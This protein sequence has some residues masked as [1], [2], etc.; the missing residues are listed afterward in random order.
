MCGIIGAVGSLP[1]EGTFIA[2]RETLAHRGP[3]D[4]GSYYD[5]EASVAL[6]HRRLSIIDLSPAGRQPFWS[7]DRRFAIVFNGELYNYR[8]LKEEIGSRYPFSTKTDTEAL[9]ASFVVWGEACL[10]KLNG[11]FAFA[12]WDRRNK[13]LFCARDRI[14]VKPFFYCADGRG[15]R[16]A[17]EIKGLLALGVRPKPNDSIIY[18]YLAY[19]YYDHRPETFFDGIFRLPAGHSLTLRGGALTIKKYWDLADIAREPAPLALPAAKER[20]LALFSDSIRLRLRSDVPV[21]VNLSSGLDSNAILFFAEKI[22][23]APLHTFTTRVADPAYDEGELVEAALTAQQRA[24]WHPQVFDPTELQHLLGASLRVHDQ[25][26]GG[27]ATIARQELAAL[28]REVGVT[29]ILEGQGGDEILAGYRYYRPEFLARAPEHRGLSQ[30]ATAATR[31]EVLRED[32][33]S[34]HRFTP[35]PTPFFSPLLNAQYADLA[36]AKLPR[37]LRFGDHFSMHSGREYRQPLLDYRLVE[38]CFFLPD[39][40]KIIGGAQKVLIRE[41]MRDSVPPHT[42]AR[43]KKAFTAQQVPWLRTYAKDYC[44]GLLSSASFEARPYWD[45]RKAREL[46]ERFFA[47]EGDNSFFLWQ[48]VSLEQWL[49]DYTD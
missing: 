27:I 42:L 4:A 39:E 3:D 6:G 9:L 48:W 45:A 44:M 8:E 36:Y 16:F 7:A 43:P 1:D 11:M 19:G 17:S 40:L 31:R 46:A 18:D 12:I 28:E 10:Q 30:D 20:F 23:S 15:F 22:S 14:G 37:A 25:P 21:G 24:R 38:F 35:F 47:G 13:T 49:R 5:V 41:A 32:F 34:R 33:A 29:V 2:A 26:F